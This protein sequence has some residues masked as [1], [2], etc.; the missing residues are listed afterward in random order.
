MGQAATGAASAMNPL[1]GAGLQVGGSILNSLFQGIGNRRQNKRMVDFWEMNNEYNHPSA[2]MARLREAGLNPNL[3]YGD[4]VSGATGMA[5]AAPKP[6]RE[7]AI[8]VGDPIQSYQAYELFK[9]QTDN[10]RANNTDKLNSAALKAA[11]TIK[12]L[13]QGD[14]KGSEAQILRRTMEDQIGKIQNEAN[15]TLNEAELV[16]QQ[17]DRTRLDQQQRA[18]LRD[19][20]F[21][22]LLTKY[23]TDAQNL[24]NAGKLGILREA[25]AR[26]QGMQL[27]WYHRDAFL[28]ILRSLIGKIK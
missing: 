12:E 7:T 18:I 2:Q 20:F 15:M 10:L 5:G 14:I 23:A 3:V 6:V 19:K 11:Q 17:L 24:D 28:G 13:A 25:Q 8:N 1:L 27:D 4:S 16:W 26:L 9:L 21:Q 22:N